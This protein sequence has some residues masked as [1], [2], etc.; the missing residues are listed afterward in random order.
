MAAVDADLHDERAP[1]SQILVRAALDEAGQEPSAGRTAGG[2]P[3]RITPTPG[4]GWACSIAAIGISST[5]G[6]PARVE[7]STGSGLC[8]PFCS[9]WAWRP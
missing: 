6:W 5:N 8:W 2:R 7:P 9:R 1:A 4:S 3:P